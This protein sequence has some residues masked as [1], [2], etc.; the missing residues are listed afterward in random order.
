[1][2]SLQEG[3]G[4][5]EVKSS[6]GR[7]PAMPR[8]HSLYHPLYSGEIFDPAV[9]EDLNFPRVVTV[10]PIQEGSDSAL[11]LSSIRGICECWYQTPYSTLCQYNAI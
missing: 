6:V 5:C 11:G 7:W 3:H 4:E 10:L 1:M 9:Y 8:P 2:S